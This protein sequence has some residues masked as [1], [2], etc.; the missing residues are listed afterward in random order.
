MKLE[1]LCGWTYTSVSQ[2]TS[3][4]Q[5]VKNH[6]FYCL[7]WTAV[8]LLRQ[9]HTLPI[10]SLNATEVTDYREE[11]VLNSSS[12]RTLATKNLQSIA[13]PENPV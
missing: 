13:K 1:R 12:A 3:T 2:P 4:P 8:T 11:L 9:L 10:K 6:Y 7:D 5:L